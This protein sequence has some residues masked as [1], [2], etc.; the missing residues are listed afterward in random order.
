LHQETIPRFSLQTEFAYGGLHL[1]GSQAFAGQDLISNGFARTSGS[2]ASSEP[3]GGSSLFANAPP[4]TGTVR[5]YSLL[6]MLLWGN[7]PGAAAHRAIPQARKATWF[8]ADQM[9][10]PQG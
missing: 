5:L 9:H 1:G 10:Y 4:T 3:A 8:A 7:A 2:S 6:A